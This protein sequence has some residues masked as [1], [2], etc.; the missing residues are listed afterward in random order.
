MTQSIRNKMMLFIAVPTV[1]IYIGVMVWIMVFSKGQAHRFHHQEMKDRAE[2]AASRFDDY[3][4]KVARVSEITAGFVSWVPEL[5]DEQVFGI[6]EDLVSENSRIYGA[7]L[8]FEPG[9]LKP[10]GTLFSPYAYRVDGKAVSKNIS[11]EV[12]DWY[13]DEKWQWWHLPKKLGKGV[14]TEP[15]FDKGAG[16]VL[17]ITYSTP[18][19][20]EGKFYGVATTDI[21]L[22][23]LYENVGHKIAGKREF[24]ILSKDGRF[25]FSPHTEE[26]MNKSAFEVLESEGRSDL[27]DELQQMLKGESGIVTVGALFESERH[28]Y[29]YAPIPSTDWTF[30][31]YMP[32]SEALSG[33][34]Q[35]M[36]YVVS[37]FVAALLLILTT[38]WIV[39]KRLTQ[40]IEKLR[41]TV[42]KVADG[43]LDAQVDGNFANDEIGD[44]AKNFNRMTTELKGQVLRLAREEAGREEAEEESRANSDFLSHMSHELRTPLN[45]IL[46]YAQILQRDKDLPT[47]QRGSV[48]S[49]INCGDHLLSLI[50]DVL[51][52]SKSKAGHLELDLAPCDLKKLTTEVGDIVGQRAR[53]KRVDFAVEVSEGVPRTIISDAAKIRQILVNLLGNAVKF[54]ARGSVKLRVFKSTEEL[55]QFDI[56]DTG[57]GMSKKEMGQIFDP[58]KQVKA[59]KAAGGTGLGL[60][61]TERLVALLGGE[62]SVVSEVGEGSTFS[63]VI[64]LQRAP[65]EELARLE[66]ESDRNRQVSR[67]APGQKA[68]ILVAD[69]RFENRE[70][71]NQLLLSAGFDVLMADDG[72][73]AVEEA[74]KGGVDLIL[75]DVYMPRMS[76]MRAVQIIRQDEDLKGIK[77]VAVTA[78]VSLEFRQKAQDAGFDDFMG[79][80]FWVGELMRILQRHLD[81]EFECDEN[82]E[83]DCDSIEEGGDL[84]ELEL[85][86]VSRSLVEKL[87][88]AM[89]IRN[90]TAIKELA[91]ELEADGDHSAL[92]QEI[93]KLS[94]AFDFKE[95]GNLVEKIK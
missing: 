78:S 87:N 24:Y 60:A 52:L 68:T 46:G 39:S 6:V 58:F 21:D 18:F 71:L 93:L 56:T 16:D 88:A 89:K 42:L 9:T 10:E 83:G 23:T 57:V 70:I 79:K 36:V 74:K 82:E 19:Y 14:W 63:V 44:L 12:Y 90:L 15:Y 51:D 66:A 26:I 41:D 53:N 29:A 5:S 94:A 35:N 72:D 17:M 61:I 95:L 7:G 40:P 92:A 37:A 11:K 27:A 59:G 1:A 67:L 54:T 47:R 69:D 25:V 28:M 22:E 20:K 43:D 32:E 49:I 80:P 31:A 30:V 2:T 8:A 48:D 76:G 64:P 50:N 33:F 77:I 45:G 91:K 34:R 84:A 86:G 3:I 38:I 81:V 73:V 4:S 55:L 75:M 65:E 13:G 85:S 62:V